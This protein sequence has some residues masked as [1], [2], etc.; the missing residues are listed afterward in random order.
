[1]EI[2]AFAPGNLLI[3]ALLH[4]ETTD[5]ATKAVAKFLVCTARGAIE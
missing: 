3:A 5:I 2:A 1:V 4:V